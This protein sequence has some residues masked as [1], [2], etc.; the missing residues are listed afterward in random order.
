[1]SIT[2]MSPVFQLGI[3]LT[4][5]GMCCVVNEMKFGKMLET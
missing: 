3:L 5:M 1:M 2:K 4:E